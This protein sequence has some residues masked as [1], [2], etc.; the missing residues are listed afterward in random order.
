MGLRIKDGRELA[1]AGVMALA[2]LAVSLASVTYE[3]GDAFN[4]GPGYFPLVLGVILV[5]LSLITAFFS[6]SYDRSYQA[7][8]SRMKGGIDLRSLWAV[9]VVAGSFA[10][11]AALLPALGLGLTCFIVLFVGAIGSGLLKPF[12][13]FVTAAVLSTASVVIFII[14]LG[15]QIKTWPW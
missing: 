1:S 8:P 7:Q 9:V 6:L 11:F 12:P 10:G 4:M 2:G 14:L 3:L 13:A 15:L 5:V